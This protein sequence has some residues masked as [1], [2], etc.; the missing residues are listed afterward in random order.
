M[1]SNVFYNSPIGHAVLFVP[2]S[3]VMAYKN[4]DQWKE[5]DDILP[6]DVS[7]IN[8]I[9]GNTEKEYNPN[10]PIYDLNGRRLNKK[11]VKGVFIQGGKKYTLQ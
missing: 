4:A 6:I 1:G 8:V 2:E 10:A 5:F 7:V 9:K 11:P 3:S